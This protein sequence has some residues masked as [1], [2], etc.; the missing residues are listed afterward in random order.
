MIQ[1]AYESLRVKTIIR[2]AALNQKAT[3]IPSRE[4]SSALKT[5]TRKRREKKRKHEHH[6]HTHT[7]ILSQAEEGREKK[8]NPKQTNGGDKTKKGL[9][10]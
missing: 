6:S 9:T 3:A 4:T 10:H 5:N 8:K 7:V 1:G 2:F